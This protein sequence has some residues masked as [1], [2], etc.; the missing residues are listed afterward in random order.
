[1]G[2]SDWEN[3]K[4]YLESVKYL[5]EGIQRLVRAGEDTEKILAM[6]LTAFEAYDGL[7]REYYFFLPNSV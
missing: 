3:Y 4:N 2:K 6:R 5:D 7:G 1:M